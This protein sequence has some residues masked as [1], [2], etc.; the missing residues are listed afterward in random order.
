MSFPGPTES[1]GRIVWASLT[2]FAIALFIA[3]VCAFIWGLGRVL[4]VLSPVLWPLAIAGII[5]YLLDP[6]VDYFERKKIS[7]RRSIILVFAICAV[8][9]AAF[10][11]SI[12]PRLVTE[13]EKLVADL[14][15]YSTSVQKDISEWMSRRP[16]LEEWRPRFF[17]QRQHATHAE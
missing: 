9:V 17:P 4:H 10:L 13:T 2:T 5:A 7:R 16:F 11:A 12:I 15:G 8:F 3:I 1:Q 14:P 6:V